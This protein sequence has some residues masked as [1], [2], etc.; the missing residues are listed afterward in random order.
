MFLLWFRQ[1]SWCGNGTPASVSSPAEGKS[2]PTNTP[3]FSPTSFFLLSFACSIYSFPLLRY[4]CLLSAGVLHALLCLKAYP[5]CIRGERC[6]PRPP[7][8]P[9]SCSLCVKH[10]MYINSLNDALLQSW[11]IEIA[12]LI[13][14]LRILRLRD[15]KWL[16]RVT[17]LAILI[18]NTEEAAALSR[19]SYLLPT[20][21]LNPM[22]A[23]SPYPVFNSVWRF[24]AYC[25]GF[26]ILLSFGSN[27][28]RYMRFLPFS[29]QSMFL[30]EYIAGFLS[31]TRWP[32]QFDPDKFFL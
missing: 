10:L 2:S 26:Y 25:P 32:S 29:R 14:Q 7:T 19:R 18:G 24:P 30:S 1:W 31:L 5:W 4:S 15:V 22:Q 27:F 6:T 11:E 20:L 28:I 13:L 3:V 16:S 21:C 17:Q 12:F 9:P 8:P 23:L